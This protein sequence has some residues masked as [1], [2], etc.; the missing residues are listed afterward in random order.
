MNKE[1]LEPEVLILINM[2]KD[3][4]LFSTSFKDKL[5]KVLSTMYVKYYFNPNFNVPLEDWLFN[6]SLEKQAFSNLNLERVMDHLKTLSRIKCSKERREV[7]DVLNQFMSEEFPADD[8][9]RYG[10]SMI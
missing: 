1:N 10:K 2:M 4:Y 8:L 6:D 9:Y 3:N 5:N 7:F